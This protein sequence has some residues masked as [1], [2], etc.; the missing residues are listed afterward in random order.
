MSATWTLWMAVH[1]MGAMA[2]YIERQRE[3]LPLMGRRWLVRL[4]DKVARALRHKRPYASQMNTPPLFLVTQL[5]MP[6]WTEGSQGGSWRWGDC[7]G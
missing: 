6:Y 5:A 4:K 3:S 7:T 1:A 2:A